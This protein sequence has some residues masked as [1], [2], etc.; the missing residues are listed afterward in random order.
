MKLTFSLFVFIFILILIPGESPAQEPDLTPFLKK[1]EAGE[2]EEVAKSLPLL[3]QQF[4]KSSSIIY[5]DALLTEDGEKAVQLYISIV[6]KFP[7]S[8]YADDATYRLFTFY[9]ATEKF[10]QAELYKNR[11]RKEYPESPYNNLTEKVVFTETSKV[12]VNTV[13]NKTPTKLED[14]A[15]K[16]Y[17]FTVQAGA[18]TRKENALKLKADFDKAGYTSQ[19]I[20]KSVGGSLFHVINVGK[21]TSEDE[22]KSFLNV[23]NTKYKLQGWVIKQD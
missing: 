3:K 11:L 15:D 20:E 1:I 13:E 2:K 10:D 19:I 8:T 4:P 6:E 16:H 12:K 23:I 5:L 18:F 7:R 9:N 21:F 17:K 22:A 14:E